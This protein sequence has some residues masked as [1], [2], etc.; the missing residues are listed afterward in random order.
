MLQVEEGVRHCLA[1]AP[2]QD[3]LW[4]QDQALH[5]QQVLWDR[6]AELCQSRAGDKTVGEF[7]WLNK[8]CDGATH[9]L[10]IYS[11]F[12]SDQVI[13]PPVRNQGRVKKLGVSAGICEQPCLLHLERDALLSCS[14][15]ST[16]VAV[17]CVLL[18]RLLSFLLLLCKFVQANWPR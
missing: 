18:Q 17:P 14:Q 3:V 7:G 5:L 6:G 13:P 16:T 8:N 10:I 4:R 11:V 15:S 1:V 2:L 12:L 9:G